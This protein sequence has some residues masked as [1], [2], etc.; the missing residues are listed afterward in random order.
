M[1][2]KEKY[3]SLS[4]SQLQSIDRED[5][6]DEAK[7]IYDE[8]I[9]Y[10]ADN[11]A[12]DEGIEENEALQ[13]SEDPKE[14]HPAIKFLETVGLLLLAA[15]GIYVSA[16]FKNQEKKDEQAKFQKQMD[17]TMEYATVNDI[18]S[19]LMTVQMIHQQLNKEYNLLAKSINKQYL[20]ENEKLAILMIGG[21]KAVTNRE[22][23]TY[24]KNEYQKVLKTYADI[25][26]QVRE[27]G[28]IQSDDFFINKEAARKSLEAIVA[29]LE[30]YRSLY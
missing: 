20:T 6:T 18:N 15:A 4:E 3:R 14:K 10:R 5:L 27:A 23:L 29:V 19:Q 2:L 16:Y 25:E 22:R 13:K 11:P 24:L 21:K 9:A 26:K 28:A 30:S 7:I 17:R 12:A 1:D 8:E